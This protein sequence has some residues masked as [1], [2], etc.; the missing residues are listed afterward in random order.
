M[1]I[2]A[3]PAKKQSEY[4]IRRE[5]VTMQFQ[6]S[7]RISSLPRISWSC[8]DKELKFAVPSAGKKLS[9]DHPL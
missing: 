9:I 3:I 7:T 1:V 8:P 5:A 6:F 4:F 2:T